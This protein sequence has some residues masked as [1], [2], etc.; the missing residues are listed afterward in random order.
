MYSRHDPSERQ[1]ELWRLYAELHRSGEQRLELAAEDTYPGVS[2]L[3]HVARIGE[4]VRAFDA[5]T[6]LDYGAGKGRQYAS[7]VLDPARYG[8]HD[9]VL[10]YWDVESVHCYDPCYAPF[11]SLPDGTFDGVVATDVLEHCVESDIPWILGEMFGFADRFFYAC[12]ASYPA[13]TTLPNGENAHC[14]IRPALWW[15]QALAAAAGAR[16]QVR[17]EVWVQTPVAGAPGEMSSERLANF[18]PR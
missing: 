3:P 1:R 10:D 16:P 7:G 17:Y 4:L 2:L 11:N 12:V 15:A 13:K 9:C 5:R 18:T 14:T 8:G 6:I